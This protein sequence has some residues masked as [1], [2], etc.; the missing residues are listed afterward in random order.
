MDYFHF[1]PRLTCYPLISVLVPDIIH[2]LQLFS[3]KVIPLEIMSENPYL[4]N[5][6]EK[7]QL[8]LFLVVE[9]IYIFFVMSCCKWT[10][11]FG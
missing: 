4:Y 11:F 5:A 9:Y 2:R 7:N 10:K 6:N 1:N 8:V 3:N